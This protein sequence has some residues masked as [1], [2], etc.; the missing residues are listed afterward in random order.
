MWVCVGGSQ[1]QQVWAGLLARG[2][3][4]GVQGG[5]PDHQG[6]DCLGWRIRIWWWI[7]VGLGRVWVFNRSGR[8]FGYRVPGLDLKDPTPPRIGSTQ[9]LGAVRGSEGGGRFPGFP[10]GSSGGG[11]YDRARE[12]IFRPF[13]FW[14]GWLRE[15]GGERRCESYELS[16]VWEAWASSPAPARA[17]RGC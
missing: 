15:K 6:G 17:Q 12:L 13:V 10:A 5:S 2:C 9:S 11:R 7:R 16:S 1:S 14:R 3:S 4:S 8:G